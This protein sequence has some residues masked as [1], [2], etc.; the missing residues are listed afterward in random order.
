MGPGGGIF[1]TTSR[2]RSL[3]DKTDN[4]KEHIRELESKMRHLESISTFEVTHKTK[5]VQEYINHIGARNREEYDHIDFETTTVKHVV[6]KILDH[7]GLK[8]KFIPAQNA[9][10]KLEAKSDGKDNN[11]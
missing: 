6:N 8:I 3:E 4:L 2:L 10:F 5:L 11:S 1:T 9:E 7:I